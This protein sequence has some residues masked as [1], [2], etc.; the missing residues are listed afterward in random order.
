M[1]RQPVNPDDL[2]LTAYALGELSTSEKSEFEMRLESSTDAKEELESMDEMMSLLSGALKDEWCMEMKEPSLEILPSVAESDRIV[3]FDFRKSKRAYA[4]IAA[5]IAV[6]FVAG[7]AILPT[8]SVETPGSLASDESPYSGS[9]VASVSH[10]INLPGI[11]SGISVPHL[12]LTEEVQNPGNL[13]L[14]EALANLDDLGGPVD[15]SYLESKEATATSSGSIV[16]AS[17]NE[18]LGSR[19]DSY[20]PGESAASFVK[21]SGLIEQRRTLKAIADSSS[22]DGSRVF[23][24]GYVAMD[25]G[26][27]SAEQPSSGGVVLA[28]FRPV[29]MIGNP[30]EQME[31]DLRLI[32]D[33]QAIQRDLAKLVKTMPE[34]S[35]SRNELNN[36]LDRSRRAVNELKR[37][38]SD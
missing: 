38:F 37:E 18:Y 20:L 8:A 14:A 2:Q 32:S 27:S 12:Y 25:G 16:A 5:A 34:G 24:R 29:S 4:A 11:G 6:L 15:A 28:G 23:V 35:D 26:L 30:V 9:M 21:P 7:A 10:S 31:V 13:E 33:F 36:L 1:N 22:E 3:K 19:V 17:M